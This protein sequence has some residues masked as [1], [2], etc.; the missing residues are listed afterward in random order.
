M[1]SNKNAK[2][3]LKLTVQPNQQPRTRE[4][5]SNPLIVAAYPRLLSL[6]ATLVTKLSYKLV[7]YGDLLDVIS[8]FKDN[9][10]ES[11]RIG[12]FEKGKATSLKG[13]LVKLT[14]LATANNYL[15][16][17]KVFSGRYCGQE[18]PNEHFFV[19]YAPSFGQV[20]YDDQ[21]LLAD[22]KFRS[23]RYYSYIC[24]KSLDAKLLRELSQIERQLEHSIAA[25][26]LI[27]ASL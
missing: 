26:E 6:N 2:Q 20:F 23:I 3:Y 14:S 4:L 27:T 12:C 24:I 9:Q 18:E 16:I 15:Q 7:R 11:I 1:R 17:R 13:I 8:F 5:C 10:I 21:G 22:P 25:L 19:S